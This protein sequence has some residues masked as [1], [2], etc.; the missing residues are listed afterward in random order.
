[1]T[2]E[3][4][5]QCP[6]EARHLRSAFVYNAPPPGETKFNLRGQEYRR[7]YERC[8]VCGHWFGR[9]ALDLSA[10][11]SHEYVAATYGGPEGMRQR[12]QRVMSLPADRS[13]NRHRVKRILDFFRMHAAGSVTATP[14]LMDIGA[15]LGVFPAAMTEAGWHV[16][17]LETD[18]RTVEHLREVA[19][20]E[21]A[22]ANLFELTPASFGTFDAITFNKVLEHVEAPVPL[23]AKAA[24]FLRPHGFVYLELPDVA[25]AQD[26]P[27]R[28]EFFIEHHH[29]F[30]PASLIL[31]GERAGLRAL[32]VERVREPSGKFTLRGF[33]ARSASG[34]GEGS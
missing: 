4:T 12:F 15:G 8:T 27:G 5:L 18:P 14:R 28:E 19:G 24:E 13:D 25:A 23:L 10:L 9:H 33:F 3:P 11:Y 31:L 22:N 21:A 6:C 29:V 17:A 1:M 2:F 30:S 26:G 16:T 34:M 32:C 20:V 7:A